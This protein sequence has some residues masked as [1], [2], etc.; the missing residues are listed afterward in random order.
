MLTE[1]GKVISTIL[2]HDS[3]V[4]SYKIALLRSINDVVLSF[5]DLRTFDRA[6]AVP[7]KALAELWVAY[8]W[9]FVNPVVPIWQGQ[10]A[11]SGTEPR[12]DM[13]FRPLLTTLRQSWE[14]EM[15]TTSRPADGFILS[16]D[17]RIPRKRLTY[18][19][20]LL[21]TH[22]ETIK[23]IG[24][25][26]EYPI[27]YAGPGGSHWTVF[28]RPTT[29]KSLS[30]IAIPVPG[31][32]PTDKCVVIQADLWR[33]FRDLSLWIEALCIHEWCLFTEAI[34]QN[35]QQPVER[36]HVYTLLTAR[37]DNRRPLTWERNNIDLLLM[38]GNYFLCPWTHK[39]LITPRSYDLDHLVPISVF[40]INELWNL[41]P[42]DPYF[43]S[44]TKSNRLPTSDCLLRARPHL[45]LAYS[46][47]AQSLP[48][49]KA[50]REDV[51]LRFSTLD[52]H[53]PYAQALTFSVTDWIVQVAESRNLA[54]FKC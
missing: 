25:A 28:D 50:L 33:I 43:N 21:D 14:K 44:H 7:L 9:P 38:E 45:E 19:Q 30:S 48:L 18:S 5:P 51:A 2:K 32:L 54:R 49:D 35:Y 26:I 52:Q 4:T 8:Y 47:Y 31:T 34:N 11:K 36:G 23:K 27:K 22:H 41:V 13:A 46:L 16:N 10:R 20:N 12:N 40:P 39:K 15:Q 17:L 53:T 6:V 24:S 1:S 3:K 29:F 42:A 37:P